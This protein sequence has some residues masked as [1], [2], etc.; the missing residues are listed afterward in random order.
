MRPI[1]YRGDRF[2]QKNLDEKLLDYRLYE[3]ISEEASRRMVEI[4]LFL[5]LLL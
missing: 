5:L 3:L 1:L 4:V 2:G